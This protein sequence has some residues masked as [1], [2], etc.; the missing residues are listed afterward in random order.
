MHLYLNLTK[1]WQFAKHFSA[2]VLMFIIRV[3]VLSRVIFV[4]NFAFGPQTDHQVTGDFLCVDVQCV[5]WSQAA[6]VVWLSQ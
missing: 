3:F 2:Y 6:V 4:N 5:C 1:Q